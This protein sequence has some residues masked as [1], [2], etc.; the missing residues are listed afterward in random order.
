MFVDVLGRKDR[1]D[2]TRNAISVLNRF[3]FLFNL[4]ANIESNLI[5]NDY[6]RIIDEY[7]RAKSLYGGSDCEIFNIYL[8]EIEKGER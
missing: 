3:K 2:A 6:D 7:E 4:P 1:A 8:D 5:K